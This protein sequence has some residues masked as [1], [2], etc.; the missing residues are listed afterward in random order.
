MILSDRDIKEYIKSGKLVIED[1]KQDRICAGWV[2]LSLGNEF[3]VF[4]TSNQAFIDV[5][6]PIDNTETMKINEDGTFMIHPGEFILGHVKE[7]I[8]IP[9]D[10]AAYVDGQSSLGR[11]GMVVHVTAG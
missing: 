9:D 1:L 2:D 5:R 11:I 8:I 10:L 6:K 4:K 7:N 3:K